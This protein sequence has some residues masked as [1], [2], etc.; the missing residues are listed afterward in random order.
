MGLKKLLNNPTALTWGSAFVSMLLPLIVLPYAKIKLTSR[1]F[2]FY[3]YIINLINITFIVDLGL[4]ATLTRKYSELLSGKSNYFLKEQLNWIGSRFFNIISIIGLFFLILVWSLGASGLISGEDLYIN[5]AL[6]CGVV[7]IR[8][9][10]FKYTAQLNGEGRI[11]TTKKIEALCGLLQVLGILLALKTYATVTSILAV[12][13]ITFFVGYIAL[14]LSANNIRSEI[15]FFKNENLKRE[16]LYPSLKLGLTSVSAVLISNSVSIFIGNLKDVEV[17]GRY[18]LANRIFTI[19]VTFIAVTMASLL[20][21]VV[22]SFVQNDLNE[23]KRISVE[24]VSFSFL[25]CFFVLS[26]MSFINL[27]NFFANNLSTPFP[28]L[29]YLI[30]MGLITFLEIQQSIH[31]AIY[32]QTNDIPFVKSNLISMVLFLMLGWYFSN[33]NSFDGMLYS[34]LFVLIV[35]NSWYPV[36]KNLKKLSYPFK[37]Y[38]KDVIFELFRLGLLRRVLK[39]DNV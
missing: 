5:L 31:S 39:N 19:V 24:L 26:V 6:G 29:K 3:L 23:N 7:W 4:G 18:L 37:K 20:P 8:L 16:L 13:V 22:R 25:I 33:R 21:R 28:E 34:Q 35:I 2:A 36:R 11:S 1:D 15:K 14:K 38:V 12:Y 30:I 9:R 27:T 32:I 17:V 10:S